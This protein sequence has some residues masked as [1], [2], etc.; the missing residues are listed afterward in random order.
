MSS[1]GSTYVAGGTSYSGWRK[2]DILD[3]IL[4]QDPRATPFFEMSG[5][6]TA[7]DTRHNWLAR[8]V[9]ARAVKKMIE[10]ATLVGQTMALPRAYGNTCQIQYTP[11][12]VT[13]TMRKAT[14]YGAADPWQDQMNHRT[15]E[16]RADTEYSLLRGN[17]ATGATDT[18]REMNGIINA[19]V[20]YAPAANYTGMGGLTFA[21]SNLL[22]IGERLYTQG[23]APMVT[24]FCGTKVKRSIDLF[25][26]TG[27]TRNFDITVR[28]VVLNISR[29]FSSFA[30][31][32]MHISRDLLNTSTAGEVLV[33]DM[34]QIKKAYY[35]RTHIQ[36]VAKTKDADTAMILDESTLEFGNPNVHY[37][38]Y[39]LRVV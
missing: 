17:E 2:L 12:E 8:G 11:V 20:D 22:D 13:R 1:L 38:M 24:L 5:V 7:K 34:S 29:Y 37:F 14:V 23:D 6:T 15:Y 35:D 16:H 30:V 4:D 25:S 33:C 28:E 36:P 27:A 31:I 19:I 21:E 18:A 32:E 39:Q 9:K 26:A 3:M 10:G